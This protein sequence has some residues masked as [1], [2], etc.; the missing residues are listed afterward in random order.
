MTTGYLSLREEVR[1]IVRQP[2]RLDTILAEAPR[3]AQ[4]WA[5][6][7][8]ARQQRTQADPA[9]YERLRQ[10]GVHLM[11]VPTELGGTWEDLPQT[12][13]PFCTLLRTLAQGDP[14]ITLASAMH[15]LV[16]SS[17][18]MPTV[19]AP[20]TDLWTQQRREVFQTVLDGCWWGTIISEPGSGGDINKT[21]SEAEPEKPPLHYRINGLKHFGSGSGLTSFMTTQAVPAGETAPDLFYIETRNHPWDGS[22]G[23]KLTA[24]WRG[25]GMSSTNS[26]AFEFT[27]FPAT[28]VAWPGHRAELMEANGGLG[29]MAFTSVIT[30]VVDAAMAYTRQRLKDTLGQGGALRALQQVEWA[31]AEQEAWLIQQAWEGAIRTFD[32]GTQNRRTVLLAKT[33]IA[34]LAESVLRRL[35][36]LSGGTA[37]TWYSPLGAWFEDVRALGYLRPP[38]TL[39][40]DQLATMSWQEEL[41]TD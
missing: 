2:L 9:D 40:Y 29:G 18:R 15:Q 25:H 1:I 10:L 36:Q 20:Y 19:P 24:P 26:H 17:W 32:Q 8:S 31:N 22:T 4:G 34:H 37:Y 41:L 3:L 5:A 39:A 21:R 16:L 12:A 13:R 6:E 33:S 14:S 38:W 11:A 27:N 23:M 7:R 30:G 35:C 28:R